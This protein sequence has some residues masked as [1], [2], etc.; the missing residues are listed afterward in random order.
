MAYPEREVYVL[1]GDGSYLMMA[2]E[3]VTSLQEHCKLNIVLLDNHGFSSIG[4][5]SQSCGN[6]GMGTEYRFPR[7]QGKIRW[8]PSCPS[9]SKQTPP[10]WELGRFVH[11]LAKI[12]DLRWTAAQTTA[13]FGCGE[14]KRRS[15][16]GFQATNPGGMCRSQKCRSERASRLHAAHTMKHAKRNVTSFRTERGRVQTTAGAAPAR[17]GAGK[18]YRGFPSEARAGPLTSSTTDHPTSPIA[19][20]PLFGEAQ[21]LS[22]GHTVTTVLLGMA[23]MSVTPSASAAAN[24]YPSSGS[25]YS[26]ISKTLIRMW[27]LFWM[28]HVLE[29]LFQPIQN[30]LYAVLP[31]TVWCRMSVALLGG[32][33]RGLHHSADS[34]RNQVHRANPTKC[35]SDSCCWSRARSWYRHPVRRAAPDIRRSVSL[36]PIYNPATFDVHGPGGGDFLCRARI[37]GI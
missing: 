13:N 19:A 7:R 21:V 20:V 36:Q 31:F 14:S 27:D 25:V 35:C 34:S 1:V 30:S 33:H 5:L 28:G 22:R 10:A 24:V 3:I 37:I 4:G 29:Y 23:A 11:A 16:R 26:Y 32:A 17:S 6:D 15:T 2:Q 18:K 12:L 8:R 9:T